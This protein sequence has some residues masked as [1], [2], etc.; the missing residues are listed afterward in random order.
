MNV[1][2]IKSLIV[3]CGIVALMAA[4]FQV[5]FDL[6]TVIHKSFMVQT[7]ELVAAPTRLSPKALEPMKRA[8]IGLTFYPPATT[9]TGS[10][11]VAIGR[12]S[13]EAV[14]TGFEKE[15]QYLR[16]FSAACLEEF[17]KAN[18]AVLAEGGAGITIG[19]DN[20]STRPPM[21]TGIE[22]GETRQGKASE[23]KEGAPYEQKSGREGSSVSCTRQD[24]ARR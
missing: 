14:L 21:S 12:R 15:N 1:E 11:N 8:T 3:G 16:C 19:K 4:V 23:R 13:L 22:N 10:N 17:F 24:P 5:G 6:G 20:I 18:K 2:N 7:E 9:I